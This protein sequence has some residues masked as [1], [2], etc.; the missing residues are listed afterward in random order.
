MVAYEVDG[1]TYRS[2]WRPRELR[3][4]VTLPPGHRVVGGEV[5]AEEGGRVS[6]TVTAE[7]FRFRQPPGDPAEAEATVVLGR[8]L[9]DRIVVDRTGRR[10]PLAQTDQQPATAAEPAGDQA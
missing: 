5:L 7:R 8:P 1:L 6:I 2:G 4:L 9:D 10:I 3:L